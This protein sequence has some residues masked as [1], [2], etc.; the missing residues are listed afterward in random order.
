MAVGLLVFL[1]GSLIL[2]VLWRRHL[3]RPGSH[4]FFRYFAFVF[5]IGLTLLNG[6]AWLVDPLAGRQLVSWALLLSSAVLALV[7]GR[8]LRRLGRP[9]SGIEPTTALVTSGIYAYIR[10]PLYASLLLLTTGVWLKDVTGP[11]T[12][13]FVLSWASVAATALAEEKELR[14][15]FGGAYDAYSRRTKRFFPG[16]W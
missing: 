7:A 15:Q 10:H 9:A 2:A 11:S 8:T 14:G 16:I 4:G 5:L 3:A 13:L 1:S 6:R 12:A